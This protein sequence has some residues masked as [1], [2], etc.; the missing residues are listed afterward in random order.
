MKTSLQLEQAAN[1]LLWLMACE[2]NSEK[3]FILHTLKE[4][5]AEPVDP[6]TAESIMRSRASEWLE[7][8]RSMA[9]DAWDFQ[10]A[11][12]E[13]YEVEPVES[14]DAVLRARCI[15]HD[16]DPF[17]ATL[18][19]AHQ[20]LTT[21]YPTS[22]AMSAIDKCEAMLA[23][24]QYA[25]NVLAATSE[26]DV[27]AMIDRLDDRTRFIIVALYELCYLEGSSLDV[28]SFGNVVRGE[29]MGD[30]EFLKA[31]AQ[32]YAKDPQLSSLAKAARLCAIV[33]AVD[34]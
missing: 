32:E 15:R 13:H 34:P 11:V 26:E 28:Q 12:F 9:N 21:G 30:V 20:V 23:E 29:L 22:T 8:H 10:R 3:R 17:T 16:A 24:A 19:E 7:S 6:S 14:V 31:K 2:R 27:R 4:L 25:E 18:L 5:L 1:K 33:Q